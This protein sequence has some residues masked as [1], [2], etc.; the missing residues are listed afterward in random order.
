[1]SR[2]VSYQYLWAK[3][4]LG[5][6]SQTEGKAEIEHHTK[7]IPDDVWA[8]ILNILLSE[9]NVT[10]DVLNA[11]LRLEIPEEI[12]THNAI[13]RSQNLNSWN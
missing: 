2:P 13:K 10:K 11:F 3:K 9:P 4:K 8:I 5:P 6:K 1:M 12:D 7:T